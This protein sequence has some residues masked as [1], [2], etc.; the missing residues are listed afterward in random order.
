MTWTS[1]CGNIHSY[2][3]RILEA[4]TPTPTITP[5]QT[6]TPTRTP[7]ATATPTPTAIPITPIA[8][9]VEVQKDGSM[10]AH[11]GYQNNST[12]A[13]TVPIGDKN[14]F[15][16][17]NA[18]IGQPT[19]F[20]QGRVNDIVKKAIP[21]GS[22]LRWILGNAFVD[23]SVT[24]ERCKPAPIECTDRNIKDILLELDSISFRL[25]KITNK[26]SNRVLATNASS[27][28][29]DRAQTLNERS[30][31]LYL[32][33]WTAVWGNF[34]QIVR[35]CLSCKQVDMI[36]TIDALKIRNSRMHR[37][38]K[39]ASLT[40]KAADPHGRQ[41]S[42]AE[43]MAFAG[44]LYKQFNEASQQLPRFESKCQ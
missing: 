7:T 28:L 37:L 38:A 35:T 32:E 14:K 10:T 5:T 18:D 2:S 25:K 13:I 8:E 44:R 36:G 34:P 20:F 12:N 21:A 30:Q 42:S 9:C 33:Q 31:A 15:T 43:L 26:I 22:S 1:G 6:P 24:T 17:G 40:L 19:Q 16:P 29:K 39:E 11:F 23:A 41:R 27:T 3:A 4:P